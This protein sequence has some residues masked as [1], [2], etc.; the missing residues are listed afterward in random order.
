LTVTVYSQTQAMM[1]LYGE[2][3]GEFAIRKIISWMKVSLLQ[4]TFESSHP[5][6]LNDS[7]GQMHDRKIA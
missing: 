1:N 7:L 4:S 5:D 2:S 3:F 6:F